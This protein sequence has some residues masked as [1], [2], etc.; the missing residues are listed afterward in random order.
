MQPLRRPTR[1][2][3]EQPGLVAT[4]NPT[5]GLPANVTGYTGVTTSRRRVI[6][7]EVSDTVNPASAATVALVTRSNP[8]ASEKLI[9]TS[10]PDPSASRIAAA[11][12]ALATTPPAVMGT[13]PVAAQRQSTQSAFAGENESPSADRSN[14]V[15]IALTLQQLKRYTPAISASRRPRRER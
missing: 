2:A 11:A 15:P 5:T 10:F 4:D 1:R 7:H 8:D 12:P 3:A 9:A 13:T 14:A 6:A